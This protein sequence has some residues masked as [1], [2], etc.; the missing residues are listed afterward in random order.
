MLWDLEVKVGK[1]MFTKKS[2][3]LFNGT[4]Q[5]QDIKTLNQINTTV[6]M[7]AENTANKILAPQITVQKWNWKKSI[8]IWIIICLKKFAVVYINK[9]DDIRTFSGNFKL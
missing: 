8:N 4:Q 5:R 9:K 1:K 6:S 2:H 7:Q 3:Q